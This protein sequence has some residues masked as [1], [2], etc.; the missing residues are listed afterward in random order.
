MPSC[1]DCMNFTPKT[2]DSGECQINGPTF[3][4]RDNERCPS[5]TFRP[6]AE[7]QKTGPGKRGPVR[8]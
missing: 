5:R 6:K 4:D 1:K 2:G 8:R 3:P 7:E